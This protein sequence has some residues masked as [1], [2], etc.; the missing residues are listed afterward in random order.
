[1]PTPNPST[2][3]GHAPGRPRAFSAAMQDALSRI[4]TV[5]PGEG[6][7]ADGHIAFE[8]TSALGRSPG[9]FAV[10]VRGDRKAIKI[11]ES[12]MGLGESED[13]GGLEGCSARRPGLV[14]SSHGDV[15]IVGGSVEK[16][17]AALV[18]EA[19]SD[20]ITIVLACVPK[21]YSTE[22]DILFK[23]WHVAS[24]IDTAIGKWENVRRSLATAVQDDYE[25][26]PI[27][28]LDIDEDDGDYL[29]N[30]VFW[31]LEAPVVTLPPSLR[32]PWRTYM[33]YN[34]LF[35]VD[36]GR[37]DDGTTLHE[38]TGLTDV[39]PATSNKV[40]L[41]L[42]SGTVTLNH[43]MAW[44]TT[45]TTMRVSEIT[46]KHEVRQ[47]LYEDQVMRGGGGSAVLL[48]IT[49]L[50]PLSPA[51]GLRMYTGDVY[52]RGSTETPTILDVT[53]RIAGIAVNVTSPC[54]GVW[55]NVP[56]CGAIRTISSWYGSDGLHE[57]EVVYEAFGL[58]LLF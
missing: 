45:G 51:T 31:N 44:P 11:G 50:H 32:H 41:T 22:T 28:L 33:K 48:R 5:Y 10:S 21:A 35:N 38:V 36:G 9:C 56:P 2:M 53:I 25:V 29:V 18:S 15:C 8:E 40:W 39:N 49:G 13:E 37:V 4:P 47:Y 24:T 16:T 43:G 19:G 42:A 12:W 20:G 30:D 54:T 14:L 58:L 1:M 57:D 34:G 23:G 27:A 52:G 6:M 7:T 26:I 3:G 46:A 17:T 55:A